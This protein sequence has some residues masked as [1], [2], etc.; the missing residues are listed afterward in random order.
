ME[1]GRVKQRGRMG[2]KKEDK[3]M[4]GGRRKRKGRK[5]W[6]R[7]KGRRTFAW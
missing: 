5:V 1:G 4:R 6:G 3:K 7:R 2:E